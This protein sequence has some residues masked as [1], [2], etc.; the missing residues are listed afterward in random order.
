M[1]LKNINH[2]L[3]ILI[4]SSASASAASNID[5][6]SIGTFAWLSDTHLDNF[7]GTSLAKQHLSSAPCNRTTD[8]PKYSAY[9][10]GGT[11]ALVSAAMESASNATSELDWPDLDF[12]LFTGDFARHNQLNAT[13]VLGNFATVEDLF[14]VYFPDTP[15][16]E[17]PALNLG[18]NDFVS[19]YYLNVSS[20]KP[21]LAAYNDEGGIESLPKPTN[22]W[23]EVVAEQ[24]SDTFASE[25]EKATFACGGYLNRAISDK[26]HIIVLNTV[27]W[28]LS[29]VPKPALLI[30]EDDPFGQFQ[31]LS[32][33]LSELRDAGK[34]AYIT[35][36]VPPML[37]SFTG[38]LGKPLYSDDIRMGLFDMLKEYEDAV[39][40]LFFGHVHSNELRH[41]PELPDASSPLLIGGSLSPCY[42]TNPTFSIVKYDRDG[43]SLPIDLAN[44]KVDLSSPINNDTTNPFN[45][46]FS[47]ILDYLEM[48]S[49]TNKEVLRLSNKM[50]PGGSD[51]DEVI[52]NRYFNNYY[53]G[54]PQTACD[55]DSC[56]RAEA[57]LVACGF[58][59]NVW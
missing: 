51:M 9:G 25:L 26:L 33:Q 50:L 42:T 47:S 16:I 24:Q 6:S 20:Y 14:R 10:C 44:Y 17:L 22:E 49:L 8:A 39:A 1:N 29:H 46:T 52:W 56:Q 48:E 34:K 5:P 30:E 57:C 35:G 15:V 11:L 28:S 37:Q 4:L 54:V 21:C 38:S 23:L 40:G 58:D 55:N 59:D 31:W 53:K 3:L 7:Y 18:N 43:S 13:E 32:T 19:D 36:H 45:L 41:I 2:I 27:V 12:V